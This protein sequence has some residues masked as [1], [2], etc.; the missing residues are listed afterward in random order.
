MSCPTFYTR[1][2]QCEGPWLSLNTSPVVFPGPSKPRQVHAPDLRAAPSSVDFA[3]YH[4]TPSADRTGSD[5]PVGAGWRNNFA[6][7]PAVS[8]CTP[9]AV[10]RSRGILAI[11]SRLLEE[12]CRPGRPCHCSSLVDESGSRSLQVTP[13]LKTNHERDSNRQPQMKAPLIL[14]HTLLLD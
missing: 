4:R 7:L 10:R 5:V 9:V 3:S 14:S 1:A 8:S 6:S 12:Q 13:Y 2:R 11:P